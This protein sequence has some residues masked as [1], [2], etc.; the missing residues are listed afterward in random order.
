MRTFLFVIL[1]T[2]C[3]NDP[4][5]MGG[6]TRPNF[7]GSWVNTGGSVLVTC[8]GMPQQTGMLAAGDLQIT[9]A[10]GTGANAVTL[11]FASPPGCVVPA[12]VSGNTATVGADHVCTVSGGTLIV[13]G[14]GTFTTSDGMNLN[15]SFANQLSGSDCTQQN[16]VAFTRGP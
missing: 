6:D 5:P 9:I 15:A 10:D 16:T 11:T 7:L 14:G 3:N 2:A 8:P 1:L 13:K 12:T 4:V